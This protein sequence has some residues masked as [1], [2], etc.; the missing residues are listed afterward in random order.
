MTGTG[1]KTKNLAFTLI[2][3]LVAIGVAL[4]VVTAAVSIVVLIKREIGGGND[5]L[6]ATQN[7]RSLLDRISR[8]LRQASEIVT[9]L[10]TYAEGVDG[11]TEIAFQNGH[12]ADNSKINYI[13]YYLSEGGNVVKK[14]YHYSFASAPDEWTSWDARDNLNN[15]PT[16]TVDSSYVVASNIE[17]FSVW[18]SGDFSVLLD[19]KAV[20]DKASSHMKS[21][22]LLRNVR[23]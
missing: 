19:V 17:L 3:L 8:D 13:S 20:K 9:V 4:I 21:N 15:P 22:I 6:E 10:P 2:E 18:Q 14:N 5:R 23:F 7:T 11:K 12:S 16:E 1:K